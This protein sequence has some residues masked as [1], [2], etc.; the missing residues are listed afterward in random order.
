MKII[1]KLSRI[2]LNAGILQLYTFK[3]L[4]S[5]AVISEQGDSD[6]TFSLCKG[7]KNA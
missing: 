3:T 6:F 2:I 1:I 4:T 5:Q 7:V